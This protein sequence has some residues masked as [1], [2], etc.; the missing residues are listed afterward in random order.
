MIVITTPTGQ[1]GREVLRYVLDAGEPIRVIM[2]DVGKL[3]D[4]V[5]NRV[6]IVEGSHGDHDVVMKAFAGADAVF[7]LV[8]TNPR[9]SSPREA[10]VDFSLP[11]CE[12]FKAQGVKHVVG[13]SALG[14]GF[15]GNAGL[16]AATLEMDDAIARTGVSYR[17]LAN[18][19]FMDNMLRQVDAIVN[20]GIFYWPGPGDLKNPHCA[21]RDIAALASRLLLDRSWSGNESL[22]VLGPEDISF[23]D[24]ARIL[25]DVLQRPVRFEELPMDAYK[26]SLI[27]RGA[28]DAIA[29]SMCDMAAAKNEGLDKTVLRTA[30]NCTP[31]TFRQWCEEVLKPAVSTRSEAH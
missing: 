3:S 25:S 9:A 14:R 21:T 28:S 26:A 20:H 1:I 13:I 7:W 2:R 8:P 19:S 11:A 30:E 22:A 29:Q 23:N 31:T 4:G 15:P 24:M 10:Y 18:A 27:A 6:E 5:R 17:A 16:A 12:A